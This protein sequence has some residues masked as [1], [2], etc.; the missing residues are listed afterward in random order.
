[1]QNIQG[2]IVEC[3]KKIKKVREQYDILTNEIRNHEDKM[4]DKIDEEN[5][6][7]KDIKSKN[8]FL[9]ADFKSTKKDLENVI[10]ETKEKLK[11]SQDKLDLAVKSYKSMT[12]ELKR[13]TELIKN[14]NN[15]EMLVP[16][17]PKIEEINNA[18]KTRRQTTRKDVMVNKTINTES[19]G[20]RVNTISENDNLKTITSGSIENNKTK[21]SIKSSVRE[22]KKKK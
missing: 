19:N 15:P 18:R 13:K 1:M 5:K 16:I 2:E 14:M 4:N 22:S 12:R 11:I 10:L 6:V 17:K 21:E 9:E 8:S 20:T 3:Q 7:L